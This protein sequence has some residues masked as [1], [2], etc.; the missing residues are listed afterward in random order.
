MTDFM[1]ALLII[2]AVIIIGY[3]AEC[4]YNSYCERKFNEA[5]FKKDMDAYIVASILEKRGKK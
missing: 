4:A 1:W 2:F 3:S 5:M